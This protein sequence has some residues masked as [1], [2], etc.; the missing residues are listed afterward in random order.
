MRN[1]QS[2]K[3]LG[4]HLY[5]ERPR[6]HRAG[7]PEEDRRRGRPG[8]IVVYSTCIVLRAFVLTLS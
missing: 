7:P 1:T 4:S 5:E 6:C 3:G 8:M 2:G